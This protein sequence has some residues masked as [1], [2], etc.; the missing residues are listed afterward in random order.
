M[1][2]IYTGECDVGNL[3]L[4][5]FLAV[6]KDLEI[7]GL[8]EHTDRN[9]MAESRVE[10]KNKKKEHKLEREDEH[11]FGVKSEIETPSQEEMKLITSGQQE[12][13]ENIGGT[14]CNLE[15]EKPWQNSS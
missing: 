5:D 8:M 11:S 2:F 14:E 15:Y 7:D 4:Q 12:V 1:K 6:G 13:V 10:N 3:E 9:Y